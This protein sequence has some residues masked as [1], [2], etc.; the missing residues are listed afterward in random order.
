[1]R[2]LATDPLPSDHDIVLCGDEHTGNILSHDDGIEQ[3]HDYVLAENNRFV[4]KMGDRI[5]AIASDDKRFDETAKTQIPLQQANIAIEQDRRIASRTLLRLI[6][7]H[8]LKLWRFGNLAEYIAKEL[9]N[10]YGTYTAVLTVCDKYGPMYRMWLS[11]GFGSLNSNA[12]DY[13]QRIGNRKAG[14]KMKLKYK[15]SDCLIMAM[16]HTHQLLTAEPIHQL[17]LTHAEGRPKQHYRQCDDQLAAFI[18]PDLKWYANTG[19]FLKQYGDGVSGYGEVKGFD[20]V[21][22]GSIVVR[23]RDRKVIA[24]DELIV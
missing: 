1:M 18:D 5:D 20:P 21:P 16:G 8:E 17:H 23:V 14:L 19:S 11:H 15:A 24:V 6:G 13:E 4:V 7:N 2:V 22:M 9:N 10:P 12:K 3:V